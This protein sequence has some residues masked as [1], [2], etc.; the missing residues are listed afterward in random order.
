MRTIIVN[1]IK[2]LDITTIGVDGGRGKGVDD[3]VR[4]LFRKRGL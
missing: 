4:R 1:I 2:S 3:K